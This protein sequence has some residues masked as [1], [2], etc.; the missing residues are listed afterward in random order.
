MSRFPLLGIL[1]AGLAFAATAQAAEPDAPVI[2][3]AHYM[4]QV[5][6]AQLDANGHAH[7][8]TDCFPFVTRA[9]DCNEQ[10]IRYALDAGINGFQML[11]F[12]DP[13]MFEAA[14]RVRAQTGQTF[15]VNPLWCD[16]NADFDKAVEQMGKFAVAHKDDPHVARLGGKQLHFFYGTVKWAGEKQQNVATA[17]ERIKSMGVEV[18]F[19]PEASPADKY[20]FDRAEIRYSPWPFP[21]RPLPGPFKWLAENQWDGLNTWHPND[22]PYTSATALMARLRQG[23][24]PNFVFVPAFWPGYDS[25]NRAGQAIHCPG[26]GLKVIRDNLRLWVDLGYKQLVAVTWNDVNETML[27]PSTRSPF[28]FSAIMRYYHQLAVDRRSP[29]ASPQVVVSY[30][31]EVMYG[32]ELTFQA[33]YL[34]ERDAA[35]LDYLCQVRFED[36]DGSEAAALTLRSTVPGEQQDALAEGRLDTTAFAGRVEA[37]SPVVDIVQVDRITNERRPL[38]SGLRLPPVILR[39]NKVQFFTPYA[40]ALDRVAADETLTLAWTGSQAP[41]QRVRTGTL[42]ALTANVAGPEPLRRLALAESRLT[43]GAFRA[44]D[45]ARDKNGVVEAFLRVRS[46]RNPTFTVTLSKGQIVERYADH[47]D[48]PRVWAKVDAASAESAAFPHGQGRPPWGAL[49]DAIGKP[50]FRLLAPPDSHITLTPKGADKPVLE[51]TLAEL[52]GGARIASTAI[53]GEKTAFRME[54]TLDACEVN[55]DY[56]LPA[57]G[58]YCR[59]IPVEPRGDATRYFHAWALTASDRIAYSRPLALIR[60]PVQTAKAVLRDPETPVPCR[61]IRTRGS[62]DDFVNSSSSASQNYYTA[63]D[64]YEAQLP[65]R[66][67]PCYLYDF[68]EGAGT[69][70]NDSGT[71]H[72]TGRAWL[73]GD[74]QW[75]ADGWRGTG[76]HLGGD[77]IRLRAK[78]FPHGAYTFSARVRVAEPARFAPLAGDGDSWQGIT[79]QRLRLDLLADGRVQARR[80]LPGSEGTAVSNAVLHPGW[81]HIVVTHDLFALRIYLDGVL[82]GEGPVSRPGYQRTHST[83]TIGM[84]SVERILKGQNQPA[85]MFTG[86]LDQIEILGTALGPE[87]VQALYKQGQW[88]A[89]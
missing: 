22:V 2:F 78:S 24:N 74:C 80:E 23:P 14:R 49:Q 46:D 83:P 6:T 30:E 31:P 27:L 21:G 82:A 19:L 77:S 58:E 3:W 36:L 65:A 35:S 81:N 79:S 4:P 68:E 84:A 17:R 75:L 16:Q 64:V 12:P 32:D 66:L 61:F 87:Q 48:T 73:E 57:V 55:V 39:Y 52:A 53:A 18:L 69:Q 10:H 50:V 67:V 38:H 1:G 70:L 20:L 59:H 86:D 37:L 29:F 34:P 43:R 25:S 51:T 41:Q 45:Q 13:K 44:E 60:T 8:G 85:T 89:R 56:P 33:L 63:A 71:A 42:P 26:Y 72:Q 62:F 28:G 5:G 76:I 88:L 11:T 9:P 47:W 40:I 54:L 15:Y 7:G